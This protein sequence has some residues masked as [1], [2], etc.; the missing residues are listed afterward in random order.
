MLRNYHSLPLCKKGPIHGDFNPGKNEYEG[1]RKSIA[2]TQSIV[3][4]I[5]LEA[6]V[7]T[8]T[9]AI[10]VMLSYGDRQPISSTAFAGINRRSFSEV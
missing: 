10:R 3:S 9:T 2:Q 4:V 8:S 7:D 1:G 6:A 5:Q